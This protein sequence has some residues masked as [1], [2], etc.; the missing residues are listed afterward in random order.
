MASIT[1]AV[2][3]ATPDPTRPMLT[4]YDDATGERTE[5][6]G[7]TLGNWAAKTANFFRDE[8]GVA[9]GDTVVVDLPEH[10]QTVAI[11]LGAW[12]AGATVATA[13]TG[14]A[15]VVV[16]SA[17]RLDDHPD[18]DEVVVASLDAFG[19]G[20]PGLPLGVTDF[21]PAV[22]IHG[23]AFTPG[24]VGATALGTRSTS[25]VLDAGRS[26]AAA[27]GVT[28]GSRVLSTR[29]WRDGEAI[30]ANL[31]APLVTGA[32]LV[33]VAHADEAKLAARA[34]SERAVLILR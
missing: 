10:W 24:P 7:V 32:G 15:A 8:M 18:A 3:A 29:A 12:W 16:T 1:D 17:D 26:A 9:P 22:R 6:S 28:A 11:L 30:V 19:M 31:L 33:V 4:F 14:G 23:D 21:G 5:L 34:E 25:D 13:D 20:V 2:L 27:D